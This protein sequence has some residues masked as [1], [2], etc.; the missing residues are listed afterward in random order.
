M[1]KRRAINAVL[2]STADGFLRQGLQFA[3]AVAL[4]RL[5]GPSEFGTIALLAIFT[6]IGTVLLDGGFSAAL[7]QRQDVDRVDESTVF[8]FNAGIGAVVALVLCALAPAIAAFYHQP[9]LVPLMLV[10]ALNVFLSALGAIHATLLA[11]ELDFRTIMKVGATANFVSGCVAIWMAFAGYGVWALAIQAIAMTAVS[12]GLFW[13]LHRWRP[14]FVFNRGSVRKLFGF[15]GYHFASTMM[16]IVYSRL[17]TLLLGRFYSVRELG[18]YNNA[19]NTKQ[20]SCSFFTSIL[21]RVAFP[22]FSSAADDKAVLRR[23]VQ[24]A[25]RGMMLLNVPMMIGMAAV[26][27]PLVLTLF[28][29]NW[30]P[31]VPVLRVLCLV[32]V[33]WPLQVIN[34]QALMA[35]GHSGLMFRLEVTKKSI[36]LVLLGVGACFGMMGIAWSQVLSSSVSFVINARYSRQLL[37]YSAA[38][39]TRDFLPIVGVA[40][41]MAG[42]VH[43][44]DMRLALQPQLELLVLAGFGACVFALLGW[45]FRLASMDEMVALLRDHR[46]P[47]PHTS[48]EP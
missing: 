34:L 21:M 17:Y 19:D 22:M 33:L 24:V 7:I 16:E 6:G 30:L 42:A 4:A 3:V 23:G 38:D 20:M 2:W 25:A 41:L 11:K 29:A 9:V 13:T 39:Q 40:T 1:L 26:A 27:R 45:L 37:D 31:M 48:K 15:G 43:W 12:T 46:I 14:L 47:P 44:L 10:M 35:Q 28:G 36:G 18:L 8:W 5:L 32:G